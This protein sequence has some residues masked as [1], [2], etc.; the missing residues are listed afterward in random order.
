[1]DNFRVIWPNLAKSSPQ[2]SIETKAKYNSALN[3]SIKNLLSFDLISANFSF[4]VFVFGPI[5]VNLPPPQNKMLA[6][7]NSSS[8]AICVA[9][10]SQSSVR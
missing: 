10:A 5:I 9:I 3:S 4:A 8:S 2:H 1:M 7:H 6:S